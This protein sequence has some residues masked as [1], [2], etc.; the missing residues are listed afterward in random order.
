ME[1]P[2]IYFYSDH[3][4]TV[5]VS[6]HF[7]QGIIT[8]WYPQA[9]R[10]GPS[11]VL[12]SPFVATV[13]AYAQKIGVKPSF[14]L[15][16]LLKNHASGQSLA[17]WKDVEILP[18]DR[19]STPPVPTDSSG[20]HYFSAR[21]TDANHLKIQSFNGTN[22]ITETEKFIFYRGVGN[23]STPLHVIM[24]AANQVDLHNLGTGPLAH[25]FIVDVK[26]G[27]GW[28]TRVDRL[29]SGSQQSV[30]IGNENDRLEF[31]AFS[32]KLSESMAGALLEEGLYPREAS[33]MVN[34]WRDS[35]FKEEGMR[36]LY[37][38]P[39][40]WTDGILPLKLDPAPEKVVRVMVG[41]AELLCKPLQE[42]LSSDFAKAA[43]GDIGAAAEAVAKLKKLG[44]FAEP[45][46]QLATKPLDTKTRQ[47]AWALLRK[48]ASVEN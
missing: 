48:S 29:E 30:Q 13:D 37:V 6:V 45:A 23:F 19:A 38:L 42:Q 46:A 11:T 32:E 17:E 14:T 2:V 44:R 15:A 35:W 21:A 33:A 9:D 5:D 26:D 20:S 12:P 41:R 4:Q 18:N 31:E 39:R 7:P 16:S 34:T 43:D 28:F 1:T 8:E 25:L 10:I 24:N 27:R 22:S 3:T 47:K 40:A 36:V